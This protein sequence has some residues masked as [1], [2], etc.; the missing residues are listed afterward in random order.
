MENTLLPGDFI[1]AGKAAYKI[2][3]PREIP[4]INYEIPHIDLINI[5]KPKFGDLIVFDYPGNRNLDRAKYVKRIVSGPGDTL[6]ILN[7]EFFINSIKVGLP[8]TLKFTKNQGITDNRE[9][10]RIFPTGSKWKRNDYGP[11]VIP[12]RGDTININPNNFEV[13][14]EFIEMD[15]IGNVLSIEGTVIT[16]NGWP[17]RD[18]VVEKD[19]YFVLGDNFEVSKDSRYFGFISEEMIIGK[20]LFVYWSIDSN[21]M[22]PGPLGFLS[23]LRTNRFL[24]FLE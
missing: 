17:I 24:K 4:I 3:T 15:N 19:Y 16:L 20:A 11:I 22:A 1:I 10:D 9:D 18:Y 12:A 5:K 2:S 6:R 14:K 23:A 8:S 21:K 13:W 7:N